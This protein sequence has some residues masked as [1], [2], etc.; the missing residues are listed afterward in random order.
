MR[1][2]LPKLASFRGADVRDDAKQRKLLEYYDMQGNA[3]S[4]LEKSIRW[5][6]QHRLSADYEGRK[7]WSDPV[8]ANRPGVLSVAEGLWGILLVDMLAKE[9]EIDYDL[10]ASPELVTCVLRDYCFLMTNR[11]EF[12]GADAEMKK[13]VE[14]DSTSVD[15]LLDRMDTTMEPYVA[16]LSEAAIATEA[17]SLICQTSIAMHCW[18][19]REEN[20]NSADRVSAELPY[21]EAYSLN[22]ATACARRLVAVAQR[23]HAFGPFLRRNRWEGE[24]S[25]VPNLYFTTVAVHA[26]AVYYTMTEEVFD[27]QV[28]SLREQILVA[29]GQIRRTLLAKQIVD[30][31]K[32]SWSLTLEG[33]PTL[34]PEGTVFGLR[35]LG[36]IRTYLRNPSD[37]A[38][39][40]EKERQ[41]V[42]S[43]FIYTTRH[44]SKQMKHLDRLD[45]LVDSQDVALG[46][47]EAFLTPMIDLGQDAGYRIVGMSLHYLQAIVACLDD[48]ARRGDHCSWDE[49]WD[50]LLDLSG[51]VIEQ[52]ARGGGQA[53]IHVLKRHVASR[54]VM[55]SSIRATVRAVEAL[56]EFGL[57][58]AART[59]I[60][61]VLHDELN[62]AAYATVLSFV[63]KFEELEKIGYRLAWRKIQS[64]FSQLPGDV[65]KQ[66]GKEDESDV[67]QE[68]T[69]EDTERSDFDG[70]LLLEHDLSK[71]VAKPTKAMENKLRRKIRAGLEENGV[72]EKDRPAQ[73]KAHYDEAVNFNRGEL[74]AFVLELV[75]ERDVAALKRKVH[76][77]LTNHTDGK[78]VAL[79]D[80][81]ESLLR[82][83]LALGGSKLQRFGDRFSSVR[84]VIRE[85]VGKRK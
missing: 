11:R 48:L 40:R 57:T 64:D 78:L 63:E 46:D 80:T 28:Q 29:G 7:P 12:S 85:S 33:E 44:L 50:I 71:L 68:T 22:V 76:E 49:N 79:H 60:L 55:F 16:G 6:S 39:V 42:D 43:A 37:E 32:T 34:I 1:R 20:S 72:D 51:Y 9:N 47:V 66:H 31:S 67:T 45:R 74:K 15:E 81:D 65:H 8:T 21:L 54:Y 30:E 36:I 27:E 35:T 18:I 73:F 14:D 26:L 4:V 82:G 41:A 62:R 69:N 75:R 3:H 52:A 61:D 56:F 19:T 53:G 23:E 5:L 84:Q 2:I 10:D 38:Q 25:D 77:Q 13:T 17:V 59:G 24:L 58:R 70:F 83:I